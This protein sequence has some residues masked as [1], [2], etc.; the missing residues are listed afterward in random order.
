MNAL[1][2]EDKE[3]AYFTG[4]GA[5]GTV[6][7]ILEKLKEEYNKPRDA[8]DYKA[9]VEMFGYSKSKKESKTWQAHWDALGI[10]DLRPSWWLSDY[11]ESAFP[12]EISVGEL[13]KAGGGFGPDPHVL[14]PRVTSV[15]GARKAPDAPSSGRSP[16]KAPKA[17]SA[18]E[19]DD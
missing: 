5:E 4:L 10:F 17:S 7:A 13:L 1:C 14:Y 12:K 11:R 3:D 18:P 9:L 6:D 2:T 8:N 16:A 19:K 15:E